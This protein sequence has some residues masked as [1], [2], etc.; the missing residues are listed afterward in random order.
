V[1]NP[2]VNA[3]LNAVL[4]LSAFIGSGTITT[5]LSS[6]D[7]NFKEVISNI[8][9]SEISKENTQL[10]IDASSNEKIK[11][12]LYQ[13]AS[14]I[15]LNGDVR[16]VA[17]MDI[18]GM[19]KNMVIS[20]IMQNNNLTAD[21]R[22]VFLRALKAT[23]IEMALNTAPANVLTYGADKK[24]TDTAINLD[25][26]NT[27]V[28]TVLSSDSTVTSQ[29]LSQDNIT[30][31]SPVRVP[32]DSEAAAVTTS[33]DGTTAAVLTAKDS[34]PI[35]IAAV[36]EDT[37]AAVQKTVVQ[38]APKDISTETFSTKSSGPEAL[39]AK[40]TFADNSSD[41]EITKQ[42]D[43]LSANLQNLIKYILSSGIA[44]DKNDSVT[45]IQTNLIDAKSKIDEI[46]NVLASN[47]DDAV[48]AA[49]IKDA[50]N[51]IMSQ[52]NTAAAAI[53]SLQIPGVNMNLISTDTAPVTTVSNDMAI[54]L[55]SDSSQGGASQNKYTVSTSNQPQP[56]K[57]VIQQIVLLLKELNGNITIA[58]KATYASRP[59]INLEV[60]N[61]NLTFQQAKAVQPAV[62]ENLTN[63]NVDST[64]AAVTQIQ[65]Q[66][67]LISSASTVPSQTVLAIPT[68]A[69]EVITTVSAASA[70][71]QAVNNNDVKIQ[72]IDDTKNAAV[73]TAVKPALTATVESVQT[74]SQVV[75]T[76]N[77]D[78]KQNQPSKGLVSDIRWV[79]DNII[80]P[81]ADNNEA[82][83]LLSKDNK[84]IF[85][86]VADFAASVK[87]TIVLKQIVS[88]I[89]N[90]TDFTKVNE[91]KMVLKPENLGSIFIKIEHVNG[92]I[93]GSIQVTNDSVK[94]TLRANLPE[95]KAALGT[96]GMTVNNFDV[97][98]ANSS[99]SSSFSGNSSN[100]NNYQQWQGSE[101]AMAHENMENG[102]DSFVNADGYLNYLA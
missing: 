100:N 44:D 99:T 73:L 26:T 64:K 12:A 10:A 46:N 42:L 33:A 76:P 11:A 89:N 39:A 22:P 66:A 38:T 32:V 18:S 25:Q 90:S 101:I 78:I 29:N 75:Y 55:A 102:I 20:A 74:A 77:D 96:L 62:V 9:T 97:T 37:S 14:I 91:I 82:A 47:V 31:I 43:K 58:N 15:N 63:L 7:N 60:A 61:N 92:D 94:D 81:A 45:S 57:N 41:I 48:K 59:E 8:L 2:T 95:L 17:A 84:A 68:T 54:T 49:Q 6:T 83:A 72:D 79:A 98:I 53:N 1:V 30:E 52:F 13:A 50:A 65:G 3:N 4:G 27:I 85:D 88:G 69:A 71:V 40:I 70:T 51:E 87:D 93:K 23:T 36:N 16:N 35:I 80:K 56:F 19:S 21:E 24:N 5:P 86:R 67:E 28:Q 34:T